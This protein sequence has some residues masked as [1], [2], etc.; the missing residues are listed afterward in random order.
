M[1]LATYPYFATPRHCV[2]EVTELE[3]ITTNQQISTLM[4]DLPLTSDAA[5]S[6]HQSKAK[7]FS[8][9][10]GNHST[11]KSAQGDCF[12]ASFTLK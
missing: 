10:R 5:I 6:L 7:S 2:Y 9:T 11:T 3:R 1:N 4:F 12:A 8:I